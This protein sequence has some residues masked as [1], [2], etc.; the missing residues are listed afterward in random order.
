MVT[1]TR[2]AQP[3]AFLVGQKQGKREYP[4]RTGGRRQAERITMR[5]FVAGEAGFVANNII[6]IR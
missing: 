3:A 6:A 5:L 4:G 1:L 2:S